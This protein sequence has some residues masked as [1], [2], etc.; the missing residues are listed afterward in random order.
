MVQ[1]EHFKQI[2]CDELPF[3]P[4]SWMGALTIPINC[5]HCA[6]IIDPKIAGAK[7]AECGDETS[8]AAVLQCP[9]C[10]KYYC[11]FHVRRAD[12][13]FQQIGTYPTPRFYIAPEAISA[14]SPRFVELYEQ[15][16]ACERRNHYDLAAM[17]ARAALEV[18][19]KDFAI[20][21]LGKDAAE[22]ERKSLADAIMAYLPNSGIVSAAD[23]VRILGNDS[24]H[25][26]RRYDALGYDELSRYLN[27]FL[28]LLDAYL[29][30]MH[31]PVGRQ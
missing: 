7:Y 16:L 18:L 10:R 14:L 23:V 12:H 29:Q 13:C 20:R 11:T 8:I 9:A 5:P 25:Y 19:I 3:A 28:L 6:L 1:G 31:P 2:S 15:A 27:I 22:V 21:E 26:A 24:A 4:K 17:G 30:A